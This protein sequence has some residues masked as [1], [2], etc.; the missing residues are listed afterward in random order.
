[1]TSNELRQKMGMPPSS[2]PKA[3]ELNNANMP[4]Y[5]QGDQNGMVV[6]Q[7]GE[8]QTQPGMEN[9][10]VDSGSEEVYYNPNEG[11]EQPS[12]E[13]STTDN[14]TFSLFK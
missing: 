7:E 1:M 11:E 2:D 5:D 10:E 3:D 13:I 12:Q 6:P 8:E 4:D 14:K 9:T